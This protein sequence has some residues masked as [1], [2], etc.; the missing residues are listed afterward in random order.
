MICI[1]RSFSNFLLKQEGVRAE[2]VVNGR[3]TRELLKSQTPKI[4]L[5]DMM[6]PDIH[7][8]Q[9]LK[10]IRDDPRFHETWVIVITADG[11]YVS[12]YPQDGVDFCFI[13]PIDATNVRR[14]IGRLKDQK[15]K[16]DGVET[17][18]PNEDSI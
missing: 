16:M 9:L 14:L 3:Q 5:L 7:G 4:V 1:L 18:P 6:L 17:S 15:R 2:V 12:S 11:N 10:L 13:K 8:S